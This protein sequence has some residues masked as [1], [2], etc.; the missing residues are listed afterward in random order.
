MTKVIVL[1]KMLLYLALNLKTIIMNV[2]N[3][4]NDLIEVYQQLRAGKIGMSE[5]KEA[6]NVSGKIISTAKLQLEYNKTIQSKRKIKFLDV[7]E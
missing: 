4:R 2:L 6:A 7:D 5:A 1:F 3:L